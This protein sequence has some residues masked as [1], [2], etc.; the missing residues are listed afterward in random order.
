MARYLRDMQIQG[1]YDALSPLNASNTDVSESNWGWNHGA[2]AAAHDDAVVADQ[3][4]HDFSEGQLGRGRQHVET[5]LANASVAQE[6]TRQGLHSYEFDEQ[7]RIE[8]YNA[9]AGRQLS[10][11][12]IKQYY[13]LQD[14]YAARQ[15]QAMTAVDTAG[16]NYDRYAGDLELGLSQNSES[17]VGNTTGTLVAS[18]EPTLVAQ[19]MDIGED[20]NPDAG[21]KNPNVTFPVRGS[22]LRGATIDPGWN[23]DPYRTLPNSAAISIGSVERLKGT[24]H[25]ANMTSITEASLNQAFTAT[26]LKQ[27]GILGRRKAGDEI[28]KLVDDVA[29]LDVQQGKNV[30]ALGRSQ[31]YLDHLRTR[32]GILERQ[33]VGMEDTYEDAVRSTDNAVKD[34]LLGQ[35]YD[36]PNGE[37]LSYDVLPTLP[38]EVQNEARNLTHDGYTP[39]QVVEELKKRHPGLDLDDRFT[40]ASEKERKFADSLLP[41]IPAPGTPEGLAELDQQI[42]AAKEARDGDL[43]AVTE[44][45]DLQERKISQIQLEDPTMPVVPVISKANIDYAAGIQE[46][47]IQ[48]ADTVWGGAKFASDTVLKLDELKLPSAV[49]TP[50]DIIHSVWGDELVANQDMLQGKNVDLGFEQIELNHRNQQLDVQAAEN[51]NALNTASANSIV[52]NYNARVDQSSL[53]AQKAVEQSDLQNQ[54]VQQDLNR[55]QAQTEVYGDEVA[56][57]ELEIG[58]TV[59][60]WDRADMISG[61]RLVPIENNLELVPGATEVVDSAKQHTRDWN[62]SYLQAEY[63]EQQIR[64]AEGNDPGDLPPGSYD[65]LISEDLTERDGQ[66]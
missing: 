43:A 2:G 56:D 7:Q 6:Q 8:L 63:L 21:A 9:N 52:D 40:Q 48:A 65:R 62:S 10:D 13:A 37:T 42:A 45:A 18:T 54:V 57:L 11:G 50:K 4:R 55:S 44:V 31:S 41:D 1:G 19:V 51:D 60:R 23:F 64:E 16:R 39:A 35:P 28:R 15:E 24:F 22:L 33:Q 20:A 46:A 58:D 38:P 29:A 61:E 47:E 14:Q 26:Q 3:D 53:D 12:A 27:T 66:K 49:G 34:Y 5:F 32:R 17:V 59:A 25:F 30:A 36:P